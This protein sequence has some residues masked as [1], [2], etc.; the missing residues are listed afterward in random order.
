MEPNDPIDKLPFYSIQIL[1]IFC[2]TSTKQRAKQAQRHKRAHNQHKREQR[3]Q[4]AA[5]TLTVPSGRMFSSLL[6]LCQPHDVLSVS[7]AIMRCAIFRLGFT[8]LFLAVFV[9]MALCTYRLCLP[10]GLFHVSYLLCLELPS[11]DLLPLLSFHCGVFNV[12]P[13]CYYYYKC[14]GNAVVGMLLRCLGGG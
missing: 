12:A 13:G 11:L 5:V 6:A 4:L 3:P 1:D 7:S 9:L 10:W 14:R 8:H 2:L